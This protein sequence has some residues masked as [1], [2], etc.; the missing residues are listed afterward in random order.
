M[1]TA[2]ADAGLG[3]QLFTE[4]C[5]Q[6]HNFVGAGGALTYGKYAP[7]LTQSTPTQIY[8]SH[9]DRPGGHAGVQRHYDYSQ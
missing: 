1:S 9:A 5:S 6:C 8:T 3:Q 2:G 7:A 4:N